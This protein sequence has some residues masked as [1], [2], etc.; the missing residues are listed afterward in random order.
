MDAYEAQVVQGVGGE[1]ALGVCTRGAALAEE[2]P[3]GGQVEDK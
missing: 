1:G 2:A 3:A